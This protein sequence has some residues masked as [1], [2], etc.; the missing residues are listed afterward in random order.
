MVAR[1][2]AWPHPRRAGRP[3]K[4]GRAAT[5]V[6]T[7]ADVTDY[8]GGRLSAEQRELFSDGGCHEGADTA[9]DE[10]E[11]QSEQLGLDGQA[12]GPDQGETTSD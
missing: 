3:D 1:V 9:G 12:G 4:A 7:G 11:Q 2:R 5:L 10:R 6:P 8:T